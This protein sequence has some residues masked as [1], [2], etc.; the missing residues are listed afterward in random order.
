MS[1]SHTDIS[2]ND[3]LLFV[4]FQF[5]SLF[6]LRQQHIHNAKGISDMRIFF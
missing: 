3:S 1:K 2:Y 5:R 6:L 4:K